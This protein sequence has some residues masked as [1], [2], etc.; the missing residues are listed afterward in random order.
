MHIELKGSCLRKDVLTNYVHDLNFLLIDA[1]LSFTNL[2]A[3][4]VFLR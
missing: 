2:C 1:R 3:K 4:Q